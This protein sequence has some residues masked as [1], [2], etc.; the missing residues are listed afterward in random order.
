[1]DLYETDQPG[2]TDTN[3]DGIADTIE[4]CDAGAI[5]FDNNGMIHAT[6][7]KMRVIDSGPNRWQ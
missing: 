3:N 5:L 2:G 1:M 4:T 6:F 7:G